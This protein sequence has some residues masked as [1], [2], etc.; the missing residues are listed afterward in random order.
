MADQLDQHI[1]AM[2][3]AIRH[4]ETKGEKD[5]YN[6]RAKDG[7]MGAYQFQPATWK[8]LATKFLGTPDAPLTEAN[9]N[10]IAYNYISEMKGKGYTPNQIAAAW[11]AGEGAL[12]GDKWKTLKGTNDKGVN[13]DVPAYV[14]EVVDNYK[15][16]YVDA[17]KKMTSK[18]ALPSGEEL[19][20][21]AHSDLLQLRYKYEGKKDM[22]EKIAPFEHRAWAREYVKESPAAAAVIPI[23][24]AGYQVAKALHLTGKDE[25]STGA[26]SEQFTQSL[27]GV[28]EGLSAETDENVEAGKPSDR[29]DIAASGESL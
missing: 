27:K 11:N 19:G 25:Q 28:Y 5:P 6:A 3:K 18:E 22:Q 2:A 10:F 24:S 20:K 16:F 23:M 21:M 14:T 8:S 17:S 15:T 4:R 7:G 1:M 9:Q 12:K 26:S 29:I 13:Y